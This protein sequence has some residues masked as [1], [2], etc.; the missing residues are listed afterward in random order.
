MI[1]NWFTNKC[2]TL[3]GANGR[4]LAGEALELAELALQEWKFLS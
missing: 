3:V 1:D 4:A 2:M